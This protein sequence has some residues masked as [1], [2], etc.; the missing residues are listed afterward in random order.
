MAMIIF[1]V[2]GRRSI[3]PPFI[4]HVDFDLVADNPGN[5]C[6]SCHN[7]YQMECGMA[8]VIPYTA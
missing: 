5:W 2:Y 6:V 7:I 4:G 8:R 1:F 3:V